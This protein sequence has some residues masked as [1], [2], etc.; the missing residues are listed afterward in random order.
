MH[1]DMLNGVFSIILW[2]VARQL[3]TKTDE[4]IYDQSEI[5]L[6]L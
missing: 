3:D 2:Y 6:C 4:K 5:A 1:D